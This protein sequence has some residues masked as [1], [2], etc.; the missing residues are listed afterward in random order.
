MNERVDEC[1]SVSLSLW[2][3]N[4][5]CRSPPA[6]SVFQ[7]FSMI[8]SN[9]RG[10]GCGL[11]GKRVEESGDVSFTLWCPN[12]KCKSTSA[13]PVFHPFPMFIS[14]GAVDEI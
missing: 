6:S 12:F 1:N 7:A 8:N 3:P 5:K 2:C 14:K 9:Q 11:V 4:F 13:S 10:S